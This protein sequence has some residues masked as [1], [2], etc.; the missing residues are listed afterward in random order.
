MKPLTFEQKKKLADNYLDG[1]CGL[2]W[3]DL[4]DIN[5]LHDAETIEDIIEFCKERLEDSEFPFDI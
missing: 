4:P 2:T 1:I 5:S 3:D